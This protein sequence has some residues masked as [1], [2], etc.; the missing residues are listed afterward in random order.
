MNFPQRVGMAA[1]VIF[2]VSD[3]GCI[4]LDSTTVRSEFLRLLFLSLSVSAKPA[5]VQ[6]ATAHG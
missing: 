1:R 6:T 4:K 5:I 2:D 3:F